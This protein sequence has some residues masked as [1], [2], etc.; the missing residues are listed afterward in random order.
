MLD[1]SGS[2]RLRF[3]QTVIYCVVVLKEANRLIAITIVVFPLMQTLG[4]WKWYNSLNLEKDKR[5][6]N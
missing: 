2:G 6:K 4:N 3:K 1:E 5:K